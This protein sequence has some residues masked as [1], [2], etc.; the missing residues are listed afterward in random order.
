MATFLV[1][2]NWTEQGIKNVVEAPNRIQTTHSLIEKA[3]GKMQLF[4]T[5]GDYDFV[6]LV[7]LPTDEVA[8][9]VLA[10]LGS[11]GNVRT[12]TLKAWNEEEGAKILSAVHP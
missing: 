11:M 7:D 8:V 6:M 9:A 2:G 5:L 12:K 4:Y 3:G 1:L 10:Y